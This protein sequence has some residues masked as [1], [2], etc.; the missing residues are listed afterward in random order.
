LN[1][2]SPTSP[3]GSHILCLEATHR[4]KAGVQ[5]RHDI[6]P[7][8]PDPAMRCYRLPQPLGQKPPKCGHF[9]LGGLNVA[10]V[11]SRPQ[12]RAAKKCGRISQRLASMHVTDLDD[13]SRSRMQAKGKPGRQERKRDHFFR[14]PCQPEVGRRPRDW[15]NATPGGSYQCIARFIEETVRHQEQARRNTSNF[16]PSKGY[17]PCGLMTLGPRWLFLRGS[18]SNPCTA[19]EAL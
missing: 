2:S 17:V 9:G 15:S 11:G 10:K 14:R 3:I 19:S 13:H 1:R 7:P 4:F 8:V 12:K 6:G 16:I 18:I 5:R